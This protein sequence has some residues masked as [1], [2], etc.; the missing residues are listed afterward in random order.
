METLKQT[1]LP[2]KLIRGLIICQLFA[3]AGWG[4]IHA[5]DAQLL[6]FWD[7]NDA[8]NAEVTAD[9][10]QGFTGALV[11]GAEF[12]AAG[13]GRTG[14][15][16]DRA[17]NLGEDNAGQMVRVDDTPW[18]NLATSG[19]KMTVSYWQ[20]LVE[21]A[22]SSSFW[23]VSPSSSGSERGA[24]VHSPWSNENI[25]F[26]TAGCCDG[27]T[28]RINAHVN[29][30][31]DYTDN[32]WWKQWHHFV[33]IKNGSNK[34]IWINGKLWREGT[35]TSPLPSDFTRFTIGADLNGGNSTRG[36]IDD[37]AVF[38]GVLTSAQIQAIAGGGSPLDLPIVDLSAPFAKGFTFNG[39]GFTFLIDDGAGANAKQ[40]V[41]GSVVVTLDGNAVSPVI[42]KVDKTT[43]IRY[44]SPEPFAL[45][46]SHTVSVAFNDSANTSHTIA[47]TFDISATAYAILKAENKAVNVDTTKPGFL[48]KVH[49]MDAGRPGG[50]NLPAP[51]LQINDKLIDPASNTPYENIID[52]FHFGEFELFEGAVFTETGVINYN[53]DARANAQAGIGNFQPD[54]PIPGIPGFT[55]STDNIAAQT[56]TYLDLKKGITRF[57]VNSDDGF[58]VSSS[59]N[60]RDIL[61]QRLGLFDG[62]RGAADTLFDVL[63]EEDGVYPI[64]LY[65]WE[66]GGGANLE[67]F[68]VDSETG[69][70]ILI[71]DSA[72]PK[73]IKAY[74][75]AKAPAYVKWVTPFIGAALVSVDGTLTIELQDA[76]TQVNTGSITVSVNGDPTTVSA[77]K[78]GGLTTATATPVG[79]LKA[80]TAY[81]VVLSFADNDSPAVTHTGQ[82]TFTTDWAFTAGTF[83][84]ETE[85]FDFGS[86]Q[87]KT[88]ANSP[89][90][91]GGAYAG[92][93]PVVNVDYAEAAGGDDA[94]AAGAV[95]RNIPDA[96]IQV[97][98]AAITYDLQR[99]AGRTMTIDYKVGWNDVGDWFNYTR[100]FPENTYNVF[101]RLSS[102]D[103]PNNARLEEVTAGVGTA[104][105][106][107]VK[108]GDFQ[109]P[110]SGGWDTMI[111]VP[112]RDASGNLSRVQL[113]GKR[114][115]RFVVQP[116]H[117]DSN[118]LAFVPAGA[119]PVDPTDGPEFT[120]V[121]LEGANIILNW[122]GGGTLQSAASVTGPWENV[123]GQSG[124]ATI[125]M[126]EGQRFYRILQ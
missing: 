78:N 125:P 97:G 18:L 79:G 85:D 96:T 17:L 68:H 22:D 42:T 26:D 59:K 72:N 103:Q 80:G 99:G 15:G 73:S 66:G 3:L 53:Q 51:L 38:A 104:S 61:H 63:V 102:G 118:F 11:G 108:L 120:S 126:S 113:G 35:S 36:F 84:I 24:Q 56:T 92:L 34:Q 10:A 40:L 60:P 16:A 70:K 124:P 58:L 119:G 45:G 88:E 48:F 8:T 117:L 95:Y 106:T 37:F 67:F 27:T 91:G 28:Q 30:F 109:S 32:D 46:S 82:W 21:T 50:N 116:G 7:F 65:W 62:G 87:Y 39:G 90:Y 101:A 4:S 14:Q 71:N 100:D 107:V 12:S 83:F 5:Q 54:K 94:G 44:S 2:F 19:D 93:V 43:T 47:R 81:T 20:K 98:M 122:T 69:E 6:V 25:Y 74:R 55:L 111:T 41:E 76:D 9:R 115:V 121:T 13:G 33:F 86:G 123:P 75:Q 89:T 114:T 77:S 105:Q 110:A 112:L 64:A 29:T 49:Q 23:M 1:K 52:N 57:G 31:A